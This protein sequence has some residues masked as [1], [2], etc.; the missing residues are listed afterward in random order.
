MEAAVFD[1]DFVGALAGND[2]SGE[3]DSGYVGFEGG[4]IADRAAGVGFFELHA[5][6]LDEIEVGV[7]AGQ[8]E[9][10]MVG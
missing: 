5:E 2:D 3:I 10:E 4:G 1:E 9:D 6:R 8:G 7:I